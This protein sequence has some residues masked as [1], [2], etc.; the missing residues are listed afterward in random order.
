MVVDVDLEA[1]TSENLLETPDAV[2]LLAVDDDQA[3]N[4]SEVDVPG[5]G[6]GRQAFRGQPGR[7]AP[8]SPV[9]G[10]WGGNNPGRRFGLDGFPEP[11][12]LSSR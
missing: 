6:N 10:L 9:E 5:A 7:A 11:G 8:V 2:G 3:G 4:G 12:G 1:G